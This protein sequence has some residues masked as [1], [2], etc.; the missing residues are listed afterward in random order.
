MADH[1]ECCLEIVSDLN[2]I[3][4]DFNA[5][6]LVEVAFRRYSVSATFRVAPR[7]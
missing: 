5:I 2:L 3:A 6:D 7:V 4:V 1:L